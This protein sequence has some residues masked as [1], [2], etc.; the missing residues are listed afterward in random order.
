M[1]YLICSYIAHILLKPN[2]VEWF[3][4]YFHV[5]P[6]SKRIT[7]SEFQVKGPIAITKIE[8]GIMFI[9]L[10]MLYCVISVRQHFI[11]LLVEVRKI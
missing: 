2:L 6:I 8:Y 4:L 10:R 3:A 11:V 1:K 7:H 9:R 5:S